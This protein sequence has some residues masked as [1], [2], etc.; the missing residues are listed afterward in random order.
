M[1]RVVGAYAAEDFTVG[2]WTLERDN[3]SFTWGARGVMEKISG[4]TYLTLPSV[5]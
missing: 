3:Q 1:G 5:T 2:G 4:F